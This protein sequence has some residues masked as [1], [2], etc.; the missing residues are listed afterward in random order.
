MSTAALKQSSSFV[1]YSNQ[2]G[3]WSMEGLTVDKDHSNKTSVTC[4][5]RHLTSF[6]VLVNSQDEKPVRNEVV[7]YT[8][9]LWLQFNVTILAIYS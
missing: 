8:V 5:T 1:L 3:G 7:K 2:I 9:Y 6:A 4:L